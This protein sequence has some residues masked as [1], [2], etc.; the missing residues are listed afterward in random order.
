MKKSG[1][2]LRVLLVLV[3]LALIANL[4]LYAVRGKILGD[5]TW[6]EFGIYGAIAAANL[7]LAGA[8]LTFTSRSYAKHQRSALL[9]YRYGFVANA[10]LTIL[11]VVS[12][13]VFY[14]D[15]GPKAAMFDVGVFLFALGISTAIFTYAA[16]RDYLRVAGSRGGGSTRRY[17]GRSD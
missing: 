1:L 12:P 11:F 16:Y 9:W 14:P 6:L 5:E 17:P 8:G 7:F 2:F 4:V 3:L 13:W 10:V 15:R